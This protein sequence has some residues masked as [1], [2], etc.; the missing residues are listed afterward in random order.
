MFARESAHF[1]LSVAVCLDRF[2]VELPA[3]VAGPK[4]HLGRSVTEW[5]PV[6]IFNP[7]SQ[8]HILTLEGQ[9]IG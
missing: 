8:D 5:F 3:H 7:P 2:I 1:K 4:M 6:H 9:S